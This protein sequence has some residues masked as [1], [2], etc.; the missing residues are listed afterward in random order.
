MRYKEIGVHSRKNNIHV[1]SMKYHAFKPDIA[2][3]KHRH[4]RFSLYYHD[5]TPPSREASTS[6]LVFYR[7]NVRATTCFLELF[8][9]CVSIISVKTRESDPID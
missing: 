8:C 9:F 4:G 1:W 3:Q 6:I 5:P 2:S 7:H